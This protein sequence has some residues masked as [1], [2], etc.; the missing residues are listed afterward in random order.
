MNFCEEC[1]AKLTPNT[2]FCEECGSPITQYENT[3]ES[4]KDFNISDY[5]TVFQSSSWTSDFVSMIDDCDDEIGLIFTNI[6]L[7]SNELSVSEHELLELIA[8]FISE[9][10]K[11]GISYFLLDVSNNVINTKVKDVDSHISLLEKVVHEKCPIYLFILGSD[12]IIPVEYYEDKTRLDNNISSDLPYAILSNSSP[13]KNKKY[14]FKNSMR[15]GRL[16]TFKNE[17][18]NDF[19]TY[20][21]N[22]KFCTVKVDKIEEVGISAKAWENPSNFVFSSISNNK[23]FTAP[24]LEPSSVIQ[25][26]GTEK[27][28]LYFNLHGA[29]DT[30][31]CD[32][33]G[34]EKDNY[35]SAFSPSN[36]LKQNSLY[37]LGVEACYGARYINYK[38]EQSI[39][40]SAITSKCLGFLGSSKIAYGEPKTTDI[41]AADIMVGTYL[42]SVKK[43]LSIGEAFAVARTELTSKRKLN[44]PD[45]KTLLEFSL[46]GDPSFRFGENSNQK[47][48]VAQK[49]ITKLHIPMPDVLGAV[50][51]EIAKVN[52]KIESIVNNSIYSNYPEFNGIKPNI[53][54]DT[55]DG[56]YSAV[57]KKDNEKFVQIIDAYFSEDGQI[58]RAYVSK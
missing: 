3:V 29:E 46:Y 54:K 5:L 25:N 21:E 45:K 15:V 17:S 2:K 39:L 53:Y 9:R 22:I 58:L 57:Y 28:L 44:P 12:K 43:G 31:A 38:K 7:L 27:N 56:T 35:P 26:I 23:V 14:D 11:H 24:K 6:Q 49:S 20:F 55:S 50:N 4:A 8:D 10:Q 16:P 33:Y 13:W 42:K 51:L 30:D 52:E 19:K 37:I 36:I 32:W 40:L 18:F 41:F 1:G 34:Q 47:S 48:F